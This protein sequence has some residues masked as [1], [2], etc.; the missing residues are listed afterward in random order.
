MSKKEAFAIK[1]PVT[2]RGTV[3]VQVPAHIK[4]ENRRKAAET[5]VK[6]SVWPTTS[7]AGVTSTEQRDRILT[8]GG[9]EMQDMEAIGEV[10]FE[11]DVTVRKS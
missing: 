10:S 7:M 6:L 4:R 11:G 1:V 8:E 2:I 5:F 9:F 3:V